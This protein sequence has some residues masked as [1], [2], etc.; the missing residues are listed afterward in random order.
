MPKFRGRLPQKGPLPFRY[1]FLLT[2]VFF[3]FSTAAGLWIVNKGI[4]P[5]LEAYA[6]NETKRLATLVIKNAVNK[7][8]TEEELNPEEL[9]VSSTDGNVSRVTVNTNTLNRVLTRTTDKVEQYLK[10]INEGDVNALE[11]PE[12]EI[13]TDG[14]NSS[15]FYYE[16]PLGEATNNVLLGNLGPKIPVRFHMVGNVAA[17]YSSKFENSGINNTS[18]EIM[19]DL[20]VTIQVIIPFATEEVKIPTS[21][22]V[23]ITFINGEVPQFYNNGG[24]GMTPSIEIPAN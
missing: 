17:D 19:I 6:I 9:L 15:G 3:M 8:L 11:I 18:V 5:S 7:Q 13:E 20:V 10:Y 21:I 23:V 12:V 4:Q 22:P 2:F 1:V 14:K 16:I 24:D